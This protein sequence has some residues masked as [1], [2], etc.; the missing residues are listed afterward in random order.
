MRVDA[1][2]HFWSINRGD[3]GWLTPA[4]PKLYRDFGPDELEPLI[5]SAG[6]EATVLVQAAPTIAETDYIL[7]I[8]DK[9]DFVAGVV[10]WIDFDIGAH[11][12]ELERMA[13]SAKFVGVRPMIQDIADVD[14]MLSPSIDWAYRA[15]IDLDLA[16][17]AL[18][19][20]RH[21]DNFLKLIDR[22]PNLRVVLDHSLKPEIGTGA[23]DDWAAGMSR[24]AAET[25]AVCKLS[26]LT[27]EAGPD[28][29][30]E[31]LRPYVAH[32]L[33]AFGAGRV[34]WGS[35]WPVLVNTA[36]YAEWVEAAEAL[37]ANFITDAQ[38]IERI[39]GD[40]AITFYKLKVPE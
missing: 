32:V 35:D 13:K 27:G 31:R 4:L 39:F 36:S 20:S 29:S 40:N 10:G 34:M 8:A 11:R 38:D 16:F 30:I 2:Q 24:L 5:A 21:I 23:F 17:D 15:I 1:H 25:P 28:W 12:A 18:G 7:A 22:H 33:S 19:F 37:V 6:I 14:W 3:Y 9:T 26:G